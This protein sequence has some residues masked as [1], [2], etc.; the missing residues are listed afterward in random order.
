MAR[1]VRHR[2]LLRNLHIIYYLFLALGFLSVLILAL[3][4]RGGLQPAEANFLRMLDLLAVAAFGVA[5]AGK[6][7]ATERPLGF[8]R[9]R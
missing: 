6:I 8:L 3:T 9:S 7:L 2:L 4:L 1:L 5:F